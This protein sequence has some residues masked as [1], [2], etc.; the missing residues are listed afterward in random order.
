V[1]GCLGVWV[2][3][4]LGGIFCFGV[5]GTGLGLITPFAVALGVKLLFCRDIERAERAG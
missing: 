3:G 1:F 5:L 2:L 4:E